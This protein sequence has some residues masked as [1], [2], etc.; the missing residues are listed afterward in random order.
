MLKTEDIKKLIKSG[1]P[2]NCIAKSREYQTAILRH[3]ADEGV[4]SFLSKIEKYEN[5]NQLNLRQRFYISTKHVIG[6]LQRPSDNIWSAL[7]GAFNFTGS[8]KQKEDFV[9]QTGAANKG[10]SLQ[11]YMKEQYFT[12]IFD[13]PAGGTFISWDDKGERIEIHQINVNDIRAYETFGSGVSWI[14]FEPEIIGKVDKK[15]DKSTALIKRYLYLDNKNKVVLTEKDGVITAKRSKN[16]YGFVPFV[17]NTTLIG[18]PN[19][20][21]SI[22]KLGKVTGKQNIPLSVIDNEMQLM[23]AYLRKISVKELHEFLHAYPEYWKY[24]YQCPECKGA[25]DFPQP[26]GKVLGCAKC[27]GTG[28]ILSKKDVTNFTILIP[29]DSNKGETNIA[30]PSGYVVPPIEI[31]QE[32]RVELDYKMNEIYKSHWG[33]PFSTDT[34]G[35]PETATGRL[36]DINPTVSR[37]NKYTDQIETTHNAILKAI[38]RILFPM[39]GDKITAFRSYGRGFI[40]ETGDIALERYEKGKENKLSQTLLFQM[41]YSYYATWFRSDELKYLTMIKLVNVEPFVHS[42]NDQIQS[43]EN[44]SP[45]DK[46]R[47]FYYP[48]WLAQI[49]EQELRRDTENTLREKLDKY[50]KLKSKL[51]IQENGKD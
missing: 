39:T 7:G 43:L 3:T 44:I 12:A 51:K 13:N 17:L 4:I 47:K 49:P 28:L 29:P 1:E 34:A 22:D 11:D 42:T 20:K 46:Q 25:G 8:D 33:T 2:D 30:P 37:L 23:D 14:L 38:V 45:E 40:V 16:P 10:R 48:E 27:G 15:E 19:L 41:L 32:M 35:E 5:V 31:V 9:R 36:I 21:E 26:D 6:F 18:N 24:A 50:V